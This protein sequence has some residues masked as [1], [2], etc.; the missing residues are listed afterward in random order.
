MKSKRVIWITFPLLLI[1]GI[2]F[3]GPEPDKP[4]FDVTLPQ[5]PE[6]SDELVAHVASLDASHRIKTA[7]DGEIVWADSSKKKTEYVVLYLHGFS[8]SKM[9]GDP[10]HR[11]FA[12][13]FGCNLYLPR[14]SD[15]GVDTTEALLYFTVDRLWNSAKD[16]LAV[17]RQLGSKVIIVGTSTGSTIG[18]KFAAEFPEQ[19][20]ALINLSP[21]IELNNPAAF[22]LNDPWGIYIARMVMGG[23]YYTTD[24]SPEQAKYWNKKYRLEALT[25]LEQLV[26]TTMT[27]QTFYKVTQPSLTLYYYKNETEQDPQVKVS[28]ML[29]MNKELG[30]PDDK[31]VLVAIPNAGF[32]V[33]GSSQTSRDVPAVYH[34]M[35]KFAVEKLGMKPVN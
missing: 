28:A 5:V 6:N 2:Y 26:E 18:L 34:E 35:E 32:H 22:L 17:A 14:L 20:H 13:K 9:E 12:K 10:V 21:N 25:Q 15:H 16:A 3:L 24:A 30:T 29:E 4:E 19:V 1:L 23:D 11:Q 33:I 8:A 27:N 31:K 7:N